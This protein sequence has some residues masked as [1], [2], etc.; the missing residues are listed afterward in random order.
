MIQDAADMLLVLVLFD[1]GVIVEKRKM[2]GNLTEQS[3]YNLY[4]ESVN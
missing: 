4:I 1:F 2:F 3:L